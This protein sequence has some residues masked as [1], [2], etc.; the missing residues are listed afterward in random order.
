MDIFILY[1]N[2]EWN[3][4]LV[5][6]LE[7]LAPVNSVTCVAL[8]EFSADLHS[9]P[10][11]TSVWI[12]RFSPS[13]FWR[14]HGESY[15]TAQ[16]VLE[17]LGAHSANVISGSC[18]L[19]L[20][21]S[22]VRQWRACTQVGLPFPRTKV[23]TAC[24]VEPLLKEWTHSD[25]VVVKPNCGGSGQGVMKCDPVRGLDGRP[26][27]PSPD[28]TYILQEFIENPEKSMVRLEMVGG[29]LL[30]ALRVRTSSENFNN[31]PSDTCVEGNCPIKANH[32]KFQVAPHFPQTPGERALVEGGR[33][34][35]ER[36]NLDV[37]GLEVIQDG[38]GQ[39]WVI[40]CNCV[41]TNYS[42]QAEQ[43]AEVPMTGPEA[44]AQHVL[45]RIRLSL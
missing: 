20:E 41:N 14:D 29:E 6:A 44:I 34:L 33:A 8:T 42:A 19:E 10:S 12:N 39:W 7:T 45:R 5:R 24:R 32:H 38:E 23:C 22:K 18:A 21:V 43:R 37:L 40:D 11:P 13:A 17:W 15:A 4:P 26:L 2:A 16:C 25:R 30:Y 3:P 9:P 28:G 35:M 31:C 36:H 27:D 1:D